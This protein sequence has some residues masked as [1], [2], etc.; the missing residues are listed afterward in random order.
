MRSPIL[1]N[2]L[3]SAAETTFTIENCKIIDVISA[4]E[5]LTSGVIIAALG[6]Y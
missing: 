6:G 2:T 4:L 1:H 3:T 5:L